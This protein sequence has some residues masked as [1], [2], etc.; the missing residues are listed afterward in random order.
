MKFDKRIQPLDGV[1]R[2]KFTILSFLGVAIIGPILNFTLFS[3][4]RFDRL[5]LAII[6]MSFAMIM[7]LA[8]TQLFMH[9]AIQCVNQPNRRSRIDVVEAPLYFSSGLAFQ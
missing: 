7:I 4:S 9:V 8:L 3:I 5:F 6:F 2:Y 1:V